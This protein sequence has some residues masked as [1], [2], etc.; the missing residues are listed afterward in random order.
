M[1]VVPFWKVLVKFTEV[2]GF[3]LQMIRVEIGTLSD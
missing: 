1:K 3:F 2:N